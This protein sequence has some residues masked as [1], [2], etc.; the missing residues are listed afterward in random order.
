M[1]I[2]KVHFPNLNGIRCIAAFMVL[3]PHIEQIK[4]GLGLS[5]TVNF[6]PWAFGTLGV[7]L[8][9]V[10]SGFL[11]TY[12]LLCEQEEQGYI[13]I[14]KFYTRRIL[15]IW[16]LYYLI[17]LLALFILP[18]VSFLN[19]KTL[20]TQSLLLDNVILYLC[21]LP[22]LSQDIPFISHTWSIRI[23]LLFYLS[24]PI[25][26]NYLLVKKKALITIGIFTS[27]TLIFLTQPSTLSVL[28][29]FI[30]LYKIDCIFIGALFGFLLFKKNDLLVIL[31]SKKIQIITYTT[32]LVILTSNIKIPLLHFEVFAILFGIVILNLASNN[33]SI[34]KLDNSIINH[35][36][37][38]SYGIYMFHPFII[39]IT[40]KILIALNWTSPIFHYVIPTLFTVL[41]SHLS[42]TFYESFFIKKKKSFSVIL[43]G[44]N[45]STKQL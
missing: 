30:Q 29:S 37:K 23:E 17:V 4:K 26:I 34:L 35:I 33:N 16:P 28:Y 9:F 19:D 42:Y 2:H 44:E 7:V 10:L 12:L 45:V 43:S 20:P 39:Y 13:S 6:Y 8:F 24:S 5:R 15:R 11:I 38:I 40:I 36:G 3:F 1:K 25:F 31:Y 22:K 32:I 18:H 21:F 27:I 41:A 14:I